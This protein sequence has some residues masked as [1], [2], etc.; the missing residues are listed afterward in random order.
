MEVLEHP[1][2]VTIVTLVLILGSSGIGKTRLLLRLA[3]ASVSEQASNGPAS[4]VH[5]DF[6]SRVVTVGKDR[7]PV[8]L[9]L[10]HTAGQEKFGNG[11][12]PS[13]L[14]RRAKAAV[15]VYDVTKRQSFCDAVTW[16]AQ[17]RERLDQQAA[18]NSPFTL[19]LVGHRAEEMA[20][21]DVST[22]E[23]RHL[24]EAIGATTFMECCT[25]TGKNT[26]SC[27][28]TLADNISA[29]TVWH[30]SSPASLLSLDVEQIN[31]NVRAT[32]FT[33]CSAASAT[34]ARQES[35]ATSFIRKTST[36]PRARFCSDDLSSTTR[37][38]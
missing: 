10:W 38:A 19:L 23:G 18:S 7:E 6:L 5:G 30:C 27:L 33:K 1:F 20:A 31:E 17:L 4:V 12:L 11:I 3:G 36:R 26:E 37:A 2:D 15:I 32:V 29:Q 25:A 16:A 28:Q 21:T 13:A 24:A 9:E 34:T 8:K 35:V 22:E 14:F